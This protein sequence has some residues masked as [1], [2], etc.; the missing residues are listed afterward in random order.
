VG[1]DHLHD[2]KHGG[3]PRPY[4][5]NSLSHRPIFV[6]ESPISTQGIPFRFL[7]PARN[8]IFGFR[9]RAPRGVGSRRR[10]A[11]R[12]PSAST[13]WTAIP[14][15]ELP[16]TL[17]KNLIEN[18]M[19]STKPSTLGFVG[20]HPT[21]P[22]R[23]L[24]TNLELEVTRQ[25]PNATAG[26]IQHATVVNLILRKLVTLLKGQEEHTQTDVVLLWSK[27]CRYFQ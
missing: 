1:T 13:V 6:R 16:V 4:R 9:C 27:M 15:G 25:V 3:G 8:C 7:V 14:S 11:A 21:L 24:K 22:V 12:G 17:F 2:V 10:F 20:G 5:H 18:F 26:R 23:Q 19:V